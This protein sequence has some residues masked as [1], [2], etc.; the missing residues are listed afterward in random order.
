MVGWD[1]RMRSSVCLNAMGAFA[2]LALVLT[3]LAGCG[4]KDGASANTQAAPQATPV[5]VQVVQK[6]RVPDF[7]DYLSVLKSR[8]SAA[9]M[10]QV[11]GRSTISLVPSGHPAPAGHRLF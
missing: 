10:T 4:Q 5:Q 2:L 1:R 9:M 6:K 7:S 11:E 3:L 8:H